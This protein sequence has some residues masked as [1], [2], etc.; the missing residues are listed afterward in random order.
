MAECGSLGTLSGGMAMRP[1]E[2][3]VA[4]G[5]AA[6]GL[7]RAMAQQAGIVGSLRSAWCAVRLVPAEA[8]RRM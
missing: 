8:L 7:F 3:I 4:L 6:V 2:F 1:R 5:E